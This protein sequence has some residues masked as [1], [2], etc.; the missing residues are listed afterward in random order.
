MKRDCGDGELVVSF[1]EVVWCKGM[2]DREV[3]TR[4]KSLEEAERKYE[5]VNGN[6]ENNSIRVYACD[7]KGYMN[8]IL[9]KHTDRRSEL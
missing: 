8:C 5:E 1:F 9:S 6:E 3:K 7:K 2:R 4:V